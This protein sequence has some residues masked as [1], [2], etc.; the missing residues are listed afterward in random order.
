MDRKHSATIAREC[1]LRVIRDRGVPRQSRTMS[2]SPRKQPNCCVAANDAKCHERPKA[3]SV[4][5]CIRFLDLTMK[6]RTPA[7]IRSE[8]ASIAG[9]TRRGAAGLR[10]RDRSRTKQIPFRRGNRHWHLGFLSG[11]RFGSDSL[12]RK[13]L[14]ARSNHLRISIRG[15]PG[16]L[17][18]I[19][20]SISGA[21]AKV[22]LPSG[23]AA[24]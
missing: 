4:E 9:S 15:G 10:H 18:R 21:S 19:S 20:A 13:R 11:E 24:G 14:L 12:F 7:R 16:C 8:P 3:T 6:Q 17:N 1:P 22:R 23:V 5:I 2:A